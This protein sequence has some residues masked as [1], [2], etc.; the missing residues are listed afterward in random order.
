MKLSSGREFYANNDIIGIDP[1]LVP[2][3]GYDG[4]L[5]AITRPDWMDNEEWADEDKLSPTEQIELADEMLRRW[6]L[7]RERAERQTSVLTAENRI[8]L[9]VQSN[10]SY[11]TVQQ[12]RELTRHIIEWARTGTAPKP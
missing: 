9:W 7:F 6:S 11:M 8:N 5:P 1:D 12:R 4:T 3:H 2:F 10:F